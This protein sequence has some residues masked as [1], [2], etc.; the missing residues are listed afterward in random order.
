MLNLDEKFLSRMKDLL[1]EEFDA[2]YESLQQPIQKSIYVNTNKIALDR[3]KNVVDFSICPIPYETNGF[4]VD[5]EKRGRYPL[6]H[7]GAFYIQ[8]PSAMFTVNAFNFKGNEKVLDMCAAPGGKT[9][10]IATRIPNGILVSNEYNKARSS[11]LYSNVERMGLDNVII[12][13]EDSTN[14]AQVYAN[15]FDVCLV[16]APCSGEG[17]FRRGEDVVAEWNEN[18]P[19]MCAERQLEILEN[20]NAVLKQGG[21]LIYSTCT[22]STEENENVVKTF[23]QKHNYQILNINVSFSRGIGLKEAVR[24]YPHVVKGE[25]QFV[26]VLQK[27]EENNLESGACL[28]LKEDKT[29]QNFIIKHIN[30]EE[31]AKKYSNFNN[32]IKK[33][34]NF[35]Y[36]VPDI[37]LVKK[38]IRY[39]SIG[40]KL[41]EEIKN[42]F[43]PDHYLFSAFGKF[44]KTKLNLNLKDERVLKYL[45]GE[46]FDVDLCDGYGSVLVENCALGGFK[47]SKGK[48]KNHYPKGLRNLK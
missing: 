25:G 4:Y 17:M 6:H 20:A 22:Y 19:S 32:L 12:T 28:K 11:I 38:N 34:S 46:T 7:A 15:T 13:N 5:N 44:F 16:D 37:S 14:L 3:F 27:K 24:L 47:I 39:V 23:M 41:G 31:F 33:Y 42:R 45:K 1:G 29:A 30:I 18:L 21:T 2:F 36:Y 35:S 8:E 10:Q 26:A 40:V 9:I 43:E 48:F